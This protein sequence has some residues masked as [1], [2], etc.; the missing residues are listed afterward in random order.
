[1]CVIVTSP[2]RTMPSP[3][4]LALM[5]QTNPHGAGIA[6]HDGHRLHRYRHPDNHKTLAYIFNHWPQLEQHPFLLHFRYATHGT[7]CETN[8]HPF[9]YQLANGEHGYIAHNGIAHAYVNGP[10]A[11][12]SRNAIDAWQAGNTDLTDGSQGRYALIDQNGR[13]AWLYGGHDIPGQTG[14]ITVSNQEWQPDTTWF[15]TDEW[16]DGYHTGYQTALEENDIPALTI[17]DTN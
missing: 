12:D 2:A 8:T 17:P 14:T 6:W 3:V 13:L 10:H 9:A 4:Q 1:M 7:I 15:D 5:S 11:N 16:E